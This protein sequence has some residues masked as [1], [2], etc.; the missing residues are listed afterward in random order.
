MRRTVGYMPPEE[1]LHLTCFFIPD[2]KKTEN[3]LGETKKG[4]SYLVPFL[5]GSFIARRAGAAIG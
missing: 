4:T 5:H 1:I 2:G 3:S